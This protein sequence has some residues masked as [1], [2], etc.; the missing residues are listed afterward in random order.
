MNFKE[1]EMIPLQTPQTDL[2]KRT[3]RTDA[4]ANRDLILA[5]AQRLFS[6][7]GVPQV[8]MSAIAQ[9]A[10]VGKGTL[11]RAFANKGELCLALMDEDMR[12]FQNQT[13]QNFKETYKQPA[14]TRLDTFLDRL[15]RFME[16]HAPLLQEVQ[17]HGG[18]EN[19]FYAGQASPH[20][21][22]P[23]LRDTIGILLR[24]AERN[25]ETKNLDIPYLVDAVL[26][27]LKADLFM[28]QREV[29]GFELDRIS[30]G[31]RRL[32]LDGCRQPK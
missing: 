4:A 9:T 11:Y 19:D 23:W 32:V 22:M 3:L 28:Y 29:L 13:L 17:Q 15:V 31:L 5:T 12:R 16:Y 10:G 27:P 14:L 24:Q 20:M 2:P 21:W 26:A 18:L 25:D 1:A 8:C 6:E 30:R 7:Q